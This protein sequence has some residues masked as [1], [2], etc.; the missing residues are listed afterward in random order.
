MI[1]QEEE[2]AD[3]DMEEQLGNYTMSK[4]GIFGGNIPS[5]SRLFNNELTTK[6][7]TGQVKLQTEES[8]M[9]DNFVD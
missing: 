8:K 1:Y 9:L 4:G 5:S 7:L 6:T 3:S 2:S